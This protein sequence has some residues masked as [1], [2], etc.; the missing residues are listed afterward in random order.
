MRLISICLDIGKTSFQ[1]LVQIRDAIF[2]QG[3][4]APELFLSGPCL[5]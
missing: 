5:P 3:I 2:D 1:D 4:E